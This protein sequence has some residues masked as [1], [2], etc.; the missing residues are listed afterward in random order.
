MDQM[1]QDRSTT[2][3][4]GLGPHSTPDDELASI[5]AEE[6]VSSEIFANSSPRR[7]AERIASG[8]MTADEW[9]SLACTESEVHERK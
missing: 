3:S 2:P 4:D 7:L 1:H 9:R 5:I 8:Q 6:L